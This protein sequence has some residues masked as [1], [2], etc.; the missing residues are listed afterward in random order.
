MAAI[1]KAPSARKLR[2]VAAKEVKPSKPKML[3]FGKPGVGK[4]W[5]ALEFPKVYYIDTEGGADLNHYQDRLRNAGGMYFGPEQGSRDFDTVLE[6]VITLAT[7]EHGYQTLVIDSYSKL[8]LSC[9]SES[10]EKLRKEGKKVEFGVEKKDAVNKTRRLVR[11]LDKLDMN[12]LLICHEKSKWSNGEEVGQTFDGWDK[13]EYELHLALRIEKLGKGRTARVTKSR[14][15][16]F[17]E[18][19]VFPWSFNE[20]AERYGRD[21]IFAP[22]V[23]TKLATPEQVAELTRLLGVVLVPPEI[24]DKWRTKAGIEDWNEMDADTIEKCIAFCKAR[25]DGKDGL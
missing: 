7:V 25:L 19:D 17:P 16:H 4:T 11:Y 18:S 6:E 3:V 14:L 2:G 1:A 23:T 5:T 20:F 13:L 22:V 8:F 10:E 12:V 9:V 15:E 24:L 21:A